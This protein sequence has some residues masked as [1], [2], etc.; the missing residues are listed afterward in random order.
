MTTPLGESS[1]SLII[2]ID[3]ITEAQLAPAF[4]PISTILDNIIKTTNAWSQRLD[5]VASRLTPQ[6]EKWWKSPIALH[7]PIGLEPKPITQE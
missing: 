3:P 2:P 7:N 5:R 4:S 1:Q 6:P